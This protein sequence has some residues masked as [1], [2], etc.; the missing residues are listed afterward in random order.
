MANTDVD[1]YTKTLNYPKILQKTQKTNNYRKPILT[2]ENKYLLKNLKYKLSGDR[3]L[4]L[5]C[6]GAIRPSASYTIGCNILC[7]FFVRL[8]SNFVSQYNV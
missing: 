3:Y 6:E 7:D 5:V 2:E 4:Y 1:D 8:T